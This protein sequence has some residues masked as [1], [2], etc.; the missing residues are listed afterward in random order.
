LCS[1]A[2]EPKAEPLGAAL[3]EVFAGTGP[4]VF[5]PDPIHAE[6]VARLRQPFLVDAPSGEQDAAARQLAYSL[7]DAVIVRNR[8]MDASL[9]DLCPK[10]KVISKHGA[11]YDN[12]DVSAATARGIVVAN[13]PGGN[14][15][16]VAE[17]TVALMLATLR[18]VPEVHRYVISGQYS[19]RYQLQFEQLFERTLGLVGLGNIGGRVA[20]ICAAGFRMR[21]LAYDP[22]LSVSE[23]RARGAEKV[24]D[25]HDLL[26]ACDVVSL[27][28][29]M[30]AG[31]RHLMAAAEFAAMK[32]TAILIN[33]AR[34]PL[35]DEAALAQALT[36]GRIAGAGLDVFEIEP[37][38]PD[39]PLLGAPNV[40]LSPHT[41]GSTV[42]TARNLAISSAEIVLSVLAGR[43][44]GGFVN[45]E[46]WDKRRPLT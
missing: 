39:N 16:G 21:V 40:V 41:A 19:L 2:I 42:E 25:L 44:P 30:A 9:L 1:N 33:A 35:V 12:I 24:D 11:G 22:G 43:K 26:S 31:N 5:I 32:P 7:A 46:V 13:V 36:D 3:P 4:R 8:L 29:P 20:R 23:I 38:T 6:A 17:G 10:L 45:P 14:A 34:G 18:R 27:H 28:L 15:D 37:P